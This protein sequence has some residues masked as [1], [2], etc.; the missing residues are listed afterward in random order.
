METCRVSV[1]IASVTAQRLAGR[2]ALPSFGD[3]PAGVRLL[4]GWILMSDDHTKTV[5]ALRTFWAHVSEVIH[6]TRYPI[7]CVV[8]GVEIEP[9][10]AC[11]NL[12][13]ATI[14]LATEIDEDRRRLVETGFDVPLHWLTVACE[15]E[16]TTTTEPGGVTLALCLGVDI[17]ELI[18]V[19]QESYGWFLKLGRSKPTTAQG[20]AQTPPQPPKGSKGQSRKPKDNAE[21]ILAGLREHHRYDGTSIT[22]YEPISVAGLHLALGSKPSKPTISRWFTAK[23]SDSHRGYCHSCASGRLLHFLKLLSAEYTP[24]ILADAEQVADERDRDA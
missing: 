4:K 3:P 16:W 14:R 18:R 1:A 9:R 10:E 17:E 24:R 20:G 22:N 23:F 21:L 2:V 13:G 19:E 6:V 12:M 11:H 8:D 5:E 15:G 7:E